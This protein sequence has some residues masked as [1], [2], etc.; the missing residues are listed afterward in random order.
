M[1]KE[2]HD[3]W[4][5]TA[6]K[7]PTINTDLVIFMVWQKEECPTT[8]LMHYQGYIETKK[9]YALFQMK[10]LFK[11]KEIHLETARKC[12]VANYRYCTK[13]ESY[14]NE[15]FEFGDINTGNSNVSW[16]DLLDN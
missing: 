1:N 5:F 13:N 15:R 11:D 12:R 4:C 2:K 10:S 14:A 7:K 16:D 8:K 6:W 9:P 3:K